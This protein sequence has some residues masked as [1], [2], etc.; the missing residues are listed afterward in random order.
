MRRTRDCKSSHCQ[1]KLEAVHIIFAAIISA[2]GSAI[3]LVRAFVN[4][5]RKNALIP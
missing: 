1:I 3:A 4:Y 2:W 5:H